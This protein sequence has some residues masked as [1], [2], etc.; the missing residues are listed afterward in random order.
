MGQKNYTE[1]FKSDAVRLA[2]ESDRTVAATAAVLGI[3]AST[4]YDQTRDDIYS[5]GVILYEP[6]TGRLPFE[7]DHFGQLV[8]QIAFESPPDICQL[9]PNVPPSLGSA[10]MR[11]LCKDPDKRPVDAPTLARSL[12]SCAVLSRSQAPSFNE[13]PRDLSRHLEEALAATRRAS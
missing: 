5:F 3:G 7:G 9:A 2:V 6:L 1:E 4:L 13:T 11:A 12:A 8:C 10:V